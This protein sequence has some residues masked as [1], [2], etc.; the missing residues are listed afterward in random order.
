MLLRLDRTLRTSFSLFRQFSMSTA[1]PTFKPF[2]LAL[3][4]LGNVSDDKAGP[5]QFTFDDLDATNVSSSK[6]QTRARDDSQGCAGFC[7][8]REAQPDRA[9][10]MRTRLCRAPI[11]T[12]HRRKSSTRHMVYHTSPNMQ[13]LLRTHQAHR[14]ML[15]IRPASP[16]ECY[17]PQ[18]RRLACGS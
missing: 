14:T 18:R 9:S 17:Q 1:P 11:L 6:P 8:W 13:R 16:L 7:R 3:V 15:P 4:Q 5:S 2:N 10:S 12:V